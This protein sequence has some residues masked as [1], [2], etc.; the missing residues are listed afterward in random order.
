MIYKQGQIDRF[1][2]HPDTSLKCVVVYGT[3]D[4]L[5]AEYVKQFA[6]AI[7]PD[8]N[9]A[10][11]VSQLLWDN[12]SADTGA[13]AGEY[14]AQSLMGGRRVVIVKEVDNNITKP[15]K[16][17]L[18]TVKSDT[19][20]ILSSSSLNK[21]SSLVAL[22][23]ER[24][25]FA[26]IACYEDRD[27]AIYTT[28][29]QMFIE[30]G[31]TISNEALQLLCSRLSNDRKSNI[32]EIEKLMIYKGAHKNITNDDVC[33]VISDNSA[34]SGDD[35]CYCAA[36][37]LT[38]KALQA[39]NKL[40]GEGGEPVSVVRSLMYHFMK[41]LSCVAITEKGESI[42]NAVNKLSPPI[43]FFRKSSFKT[44]VSIWRKERLLD[45]L[46]LLYKAERDC[47]T[48]NMPAEEIVSYLI[49]QVASAAAKMQKNRITG[50]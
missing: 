39:Y 20:L 2:K 36:S 18:E 27:E 1:L 12:I 23:E 29:R 24:D 49:M 9:D 30:N 14:G 13:L 48:T 45:V 15:L 22:A 35:V 46:E 26:L 19:L 6:Q 8:L 31:Y 43:I 47:K 37:G 32:G 28:A 38:D 16:A 7:V 4:G 5:V 17:M 25:D 41:L 3:N 21:K 33:K 11:Q 34:A 44:Q 10:F 40:L 50:Y 42:D